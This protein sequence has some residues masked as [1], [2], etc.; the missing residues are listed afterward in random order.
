MLRGESYGFS[1][2][3]WA[4]GVLLHEMMAGRSPFEINE[5]QN[6]NPD[7]KTEDHLF[8]VILEKPIR[9]PRNLSTKASS[10][11][12]AFLQKFPNERLGSNGLSEVQ[13]HMFFKS[14]DFNL[15][16]Q[17]LIHPLYR[18][19]IMSDRDLTN[20]DELFTQE[21]VVLT[22]DSPQTLSRINQNEFEGFQYV[23]PLLLSE[24]LPV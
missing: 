18:P 11:L 4:L 21:P 10:I 9:I 8:Q 19:Q 17:K 7:L 22:P 14:I 6:E 16:E 12:K 5:G 3:W 1:V 2:D 23:N 24:D 13:E 20:I 15:L